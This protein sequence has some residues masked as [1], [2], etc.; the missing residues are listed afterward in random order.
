MVEVVFLTHDVGSVIKDC[1]KGGQNAVLS[2]A[3][4]TKGATRMDAVDIVISMI[5]RSVDEFFEIG[6]SIPLVEA[7]ALWYVELLKKAMR[8]NWL[9]QVGGLIH[10]LFFLPPSSSHPQ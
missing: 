2:V 1:K 6:A 9:C 4:H 7:D 8:A 3:H 5:E 10:I